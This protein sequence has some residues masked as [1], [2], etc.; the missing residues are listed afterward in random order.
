ML[1]NALPAAQRALIRTLLPV[2]AALAGLAL[3]GSAHAAAIDGR[4]AAV[5]ERINAVRAQHGRSRLTLDDRLSRAADRHSRRMARARTL[6]HR[7]W[8][9]A[10]LGTRLRWAI[11]D[12]YA[13]EVIFWASGS[14]RSARIVRAWMRSP[15]HRHTLLSERFTRAGIGIREG[16]YGVY[17]TVDVAEG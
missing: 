2:I 14:V 10:A 9:E 4:E 7:V 8:G 13:G 17:A 15:G 3:T 1:P 6:A 11:G 16:R 5:I 12:A